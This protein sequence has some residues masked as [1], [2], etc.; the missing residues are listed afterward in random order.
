RGR[1]DVPGLFCGPSGVEPDVQHGR[2]MGEGADADDVHAGLGDGANGVEVHAPGRLQHGPA[3]GQ[4]DRLAQLVGAEVVEHDHVGTVL[5]RLPKL[6]E[7]VDL[8]LDLHQ[9]T[10]EGAGAPQGLADRAAGGDVVVLD[11]DRVV[12]TEAVVHSA[13]AT[14]GVLLEVAQAGRGLASV[15]D[16]RAGSGDG[17]DIEAGQRSD[18]AHPAHQI[19]RGALG[20]EQSAGV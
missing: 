4:G 15:D 16:L 2:G 18:A 12:E 20:G 3:G 6:V 17:L 5:Q 13:A 1:R 11:E 9:V 7:V 19:E 14:H 8:H 10:G